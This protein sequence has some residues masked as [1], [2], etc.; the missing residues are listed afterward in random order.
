MSKSNTAVAFNASDYGQ[1]DPFF[2]AGHY[3]KT[4]TKVSLNKDQEPVV[5]L[6]TDESFDGRRINSY[7]TINFFFGASRSEASRKMW[8]KKFVDLINACGIAPSA[9]KNLATDLEQLVSNI[10]TC[11]YLHA[12]EKPLP[13]FHPAGKYNPAWVSKAKPKKAWNTPELVKVVP[14][15]P[16]D[17][18]TVSPDAIDFDGDIPF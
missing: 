13:N 12:E 18:V 16:D 2:D 5:T 11:E 10:V 4:I 17:H 7:Y 15:K 1:S 3:K 14:F 6:R 9:I 8:G